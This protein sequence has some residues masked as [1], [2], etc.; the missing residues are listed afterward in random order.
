[1]LVAFPRF[2]EDPMLHRIARPARIPL[3][4]LAL[5]TAA[6]APASA[7]PPWI[8]IELPANPLDP[9]TRDAFLVVHT[10]HHAQV[11]MAGLT[12]RAIGMVDG[13]RRTIDLSF[14][15]TSVGGAYALRRTWPARGAWVLAIT[16]GAGEG[17]VTALVG[18]G[19]DGEV[20][21]VKVPRRSAS[22]PWGR[23]V[24]DQ[25]INATL[26]AVAVGAPTSAVPRAAS[27]LLVLPLA[28][29]VVLSRRHRG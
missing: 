6:A 3:A 12:G 29:G 2:P 1:M 24:T 27:L 26:Q 8:S 21:S 11:M 25:D 22:Q 4:V 28:A 17:G 9:T 15:R 10:Y 18:I 20:R 13:Q 23:P 19:A 16:T 5:L 7:G 14:T